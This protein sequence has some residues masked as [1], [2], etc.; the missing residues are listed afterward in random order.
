MALQRWY[1]K[2][3]NKMKEQGYQILPCETEELT[4]LIKETLRK[5]KRCAQAGYLLDKNDQQHFFVFT[6]KK[7]QTSPNGAKGGD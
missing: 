5:E 4:L 2:E 7:A 1:I 3:F 6:K